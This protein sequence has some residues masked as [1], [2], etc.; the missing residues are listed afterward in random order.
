VD[1][2]SEISVPTLVMVGEHDVAT[3][4]H[5]A[6]LIADHIPGALLSHVPA[7]GH[8]STI[9]NPEAVTTALSSFFRDG[10]VD[11][12]AGAARTPRSTLYDGSA[13]GK[14]VEPLLAGVHGFVTDHL[15]DGD[16]VL[17]ACC[18]TGG[19]SR[20]MAASGR[21]VLGVDLSP[22]NIAFAQSRGGSGGLSFSV[23]DVSQLDAHDD[24][25]FD[26]ATVVL[27]LHEMPHACREPVLRELGRVARRVMVVDFNAPMPWNAAGVRNRAMELAAGSEHFN[28]FRDYSRR[29][30][31]PALIEAAGLQ[32]ESERL[33]D[34]GTLRV[35]VLQRK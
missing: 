8:L 9:D 26:V 31:L 27:A 30:G 23:N 7:A 11:A 16:R 28:A 34:S 1:R 3:P 32:L 2:L 25:A 18:G 19:L 29:G 5:L 33:I 24:E 35:Q 14:L 13:Y 21:D 4:L 6:Q 10:T 12:K 15:P 20:K 17:D 22:R